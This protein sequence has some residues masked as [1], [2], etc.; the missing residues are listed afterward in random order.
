MSLPSLTFSQLQSLFFTQYS[1]EA[2]VPA[3]TNQGSTLW[4]MGNAAALLALNVQQELEY[5]LEVS[6]LGTSVS[7][8][9][10][11]N[12]PN[13]DTFV[14][15]F[16]VSRIQ[17]TYASGGVTM[18]A[19]SVATAQIVIP[20]GGQVS[21][22]S[23]IL[24]TVI[25]DTSNANYSSALNGYPINI[26]SAST[27]VTVQ[28]TVAG[29]AGNVQPGQISSLANS[30]TA[31]VISGISTVS[32]AYAFNNGENAEADTSVETRFQTTM[33]TGVVATDNA[34]IAAT[35][36]VY[37]GTTPNVPG[38]TYS[39]GDGLN[40][41]GS[42]TAAVVS[43]YVNY[44][45]SGVAAPS[46]LV[47]QVQT[48]L[49]NVKAAGI[50]VT[51]YG[52]TIVPVNSLATIHIP[53]GVT[54]S[55]VITACINA[56]NAYL[57]AIGLN[58]SGGSTVANYFAIA[59]VLLSV[60]N[61][62]KIDGLLIGENGFTPVTGTSTATGTTTLTDATKSWTVNAY[63]GATVTSGSSF[64][65]VTSNTSTVLTVSSWANSTPVSGAS[66]S[67][68]STPAGTS[69]LTATFG[70]QFVAGVASFTVSQP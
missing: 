20:V 46:A 64:G 13:V 62:A 18:T 43:M 70:N 19:P 25:P 58:P 29:T 21:T 45:G 67:I 27:V 10:G 35:L 42:A 40:S 63:A 9:P 30:L 8:V 60:P 52:P 57:N 33:S 37:P 47:S 15:P 7:T 5:T 17:A 11:V 68:T 23:G 32:N 48:A 51:A 41:S 36:G 24:F 54:A 61:V 22:V 3:N 39:C 4:A 55:T 56:Y 14:N 12:S 31:P 65:I 26:G 1:A 59:S 6:R 53:I 44:Y 16:G 49:L 66:Y 34:L 28:S 38:L 2:S 69:D 50:T